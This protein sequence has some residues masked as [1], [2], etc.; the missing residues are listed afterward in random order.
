MFLI[1]N[2]SLPSCSNSLP[3]RNQSLSL[4]AG[5]LLTALLPSPLSFFSGP[6][7]PH[8][9]PL[10]CPPVGVADGTNDAYRSARQGTSGTRLRLRPRHCTHRGSP[11]RSGREWRAG[12]LWVHTPLREANHSG[13]HC[14]RWVT[15]SSLASAADLKWR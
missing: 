12:K 1:M 10:W 3:P 15:Q 4:F 9:H 6:S 7:T 5:S 2:H 14:A 8:Q 11:E 13:D